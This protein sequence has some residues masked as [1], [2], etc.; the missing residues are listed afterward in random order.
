MTLLIGSVLLFV[1][2]TLFASRL[3]PDLSK[4][5]IRE[6]MFTEVG[7]RGGYRPT[8][9]TQVATVL[10]PVNRMLPMTGYHLRIGPRL[11]A[12][13]LQMTS[14]EFLALQMLGVFASGVLYVATIGAASFKP[15]WFVIFLGI[16][17]G[18]PWLWLMNRIQARRESISRDLPEVVDLL[19]LCVDAGLDFMNAMARIIKEFRHCPTTEELGLVLQEVRVGKRRRDALRAFSI[20]VQTTEASSFV[21]T[22]VQADRMGTGIGEAL[23]V[24][25]EDMRIARYHWA[26]RFAQQAP[27]KMIIPLLMSLFAALLIV[28]GPILIQFLRG[29]FSAP[30]FQANE[31][32]E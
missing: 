13:G 10:R 29:G 17:C 7:S 15:L 9:L 23:N 8:M 1:S 2:V 19:T 26:E 5:H 31:P 24:L 14:M 6:R 30:Q 12:A 21:R 3:W 27:L 11:E 25:S 22:L 28:T 32:Q 20:R 4:R 16:G 18:V